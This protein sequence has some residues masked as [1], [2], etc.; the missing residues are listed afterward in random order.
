MK[1][2]KI[3]LSCLCSIVLFIS[4]M[5]N[6]VYANEYTSIN[7]SEEKSDFID[8]VND[9]FANNHS[10]DVLNEYNESVKLEFIKDNNENFTQ[11][12][13]DKIEQ[14]CI[15]NDLSLTRKFKEIVLQP[16]SNSIPRM[17]YTYN[18]SNDKTRSF[19]QNY[20]NVTY[21]TRISGSVHVNDST[22]VITSYSGPYI[23]LLSCTLSGTNQLQNVSTSVSWGS[24]S[25]R[26]LTMTASYQFTT[27]F[28]Y[29]T[30]PFY[31]SDSP[32]SNS[33]SY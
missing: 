2:I 22:G 9:V 25:H 14:Y 31:L 12:N 6:V 5:S 7:S 32:Q 21:V 3:I 29:D 28:V 19:S 8:I 10:S 11:H 16:L 13:Y 4:L 26:S 27:S 15:D 17:S 18:I 1:T 23:T 24:S 33:V 20:F 30:A